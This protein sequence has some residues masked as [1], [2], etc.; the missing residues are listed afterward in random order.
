LEKRILIVDDDD[1]IRM[2]LLTVLRKRGYRVDTARNG[3]EAIERSRQCR[4]SVVLLD[5]MMPLM[6]GYEFLEQV[7]EWPDA[8]RPVVIVLTAGTEP[9]DLNPKVV[10]GTIRKPFDIE[11]LV[12]TIGACM[13]TRQQY[14]QNE[15][16]PSPESDL[17]E[18]AGKPN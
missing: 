10:A 16:C 15:N 11:L 17:D 12:D 3:E 18:S 5:L 7:E 8:I 9:R 2:L 6:S 13:R 4:Y 14:P 1:P